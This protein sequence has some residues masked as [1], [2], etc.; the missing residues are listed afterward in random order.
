[1]TAF[2]HLDELVPHVIW[3]GVV[4]RNVVSELATFSY[5]ELDPDVHVPEHEHANEQVGVLL[6]GSVRFRIGDEV[7]E[8]TPGSTWCILAH[9]PHEVWAGPEGATLVELFA[10]RRDDWGDREQLAPSPPLRFPA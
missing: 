1:V 2:S 9:V 8:L 3:P 4:G 6:R 7:G 10:P 5:L